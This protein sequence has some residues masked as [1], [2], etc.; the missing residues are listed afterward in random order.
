MKKRIKI[1]LVTGT[2]LF[3]LLTSTSLSVSQPYELQV[4]T[5]EFID[6]G[7]LT[8]GEDSHANDINEK[9]QVVGSSET[10][11]SI[12]IG[13]LW[14]DDVM[15][16]LGTLGGA[17][18]NAKSINDYGQIAGF[19]LT[20]WPLHACLWLRPNR[21]MRYGEEFGFTVNFGR[22]DLGAL[23]A[24]GESMAFGNNNLGQVVGWS[25]NAAYQIRAFIWADG[26]MIELDNLPGG[27][28]AIANDINNYGQI[29]GESDTTMMF[30]YDPHA[31]LWEDNNVA[32]LGVLSGFQL[33]GANAINNDGIIV[34]Y[35]QTFDYEHGL[36]GWKRACLW[37]ENLDII[38]LGSLGG[39]SSEA[40][41]INNH[42]HVVG[43]AT[44]SLDQ[45]NHAFIWRNGIMQDLNDY[46]PSDSDW[47]LKS[48]NGINDKGQIVGSAYNE[49]LNCYH[50]FL[51]S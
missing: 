50:A 21:L 8:G 27:V 35:S 17:N 20:S 32:D 19:S 6:I 4:R 44:Y 22:V 13:F 41:D 28:G 25:T 49:V 26:V 36:Y 47:I 34:G 48:A 51:L 2:L 45:K 38:D 39:G 23:W 12:M 37:D 3:T 30:P 18:S 5:Y 29:V 24:S 11:F 7:A 15:T 40:F 46:L 31:C 42:G 14:E 33:G 10:A 1:L 16:N 43:K 9:G